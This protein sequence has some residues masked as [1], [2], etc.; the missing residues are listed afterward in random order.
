MNELDGW[1][2]W[3]PTPAN[4]RDVPFI[5]VTDE[6]RPQQGN[7]PPEAV[8]PGDPHESEDAMESGAIIR[9]PREDPAAEPADSTGTDSP[10][11]TS[12]DAGV[13]WPWEPEAAAQG[14][15]VA[16]VEAG[17]TVQTSSLY[18][19]SGYSA[20]TPAEDPFARPADTPSAEP[21]DQTAMLGGMSTTAAPVY[22]QAPVAP[23]KGWGTGAVALFLIVVTTV[24]GFVDMT[25]NRELTWIT[26]GVFVIACV[27]AAFSVRPRDLWTAVITPPLAFLVALL[28]SGQPSTLSGSGSLILREASLVVTG[29][30]FNAPYIFGGTILAFV[31]VLIRRTRLRK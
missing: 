5:F 24:V 31:I 4:P 16:K 17:P 15:P 1:R 7:Q 13:H 23:E 21:A 26:G 11:I 30:A 18:R 12:S 25:M 19:S 20:E 2:A 14:T 22:N 28:I 3:Q 27:I 8:T 6:S 10:V 9:S 29:L